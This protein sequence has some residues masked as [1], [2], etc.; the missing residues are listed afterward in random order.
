MLTVWLDGDIYN[1]FFG[2]G[3]KSVFKLMI[4]VALEFQGLKNLG[5][6]PLSK[7]KC[8]LALSLLK[9]YI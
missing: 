5:N 2:I 1:T 7:V 3:K 8:L 6:G 4:Q 9:K